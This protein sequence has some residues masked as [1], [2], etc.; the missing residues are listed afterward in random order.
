MS[1]EQQTHTL[2]KESLLEK[3][4]A[5]MWHHM[6]PYN[7]NPMIVTEASGSWVTD[8]DGNKYLDGMSG[9]WC[10]NIGYGRQ[11]LAEAAYEQ[12]KTMA[13]F[14]LTQSHVPAIK[15]SEKVSEWLGEEYRVFFSNSGSEANEVAFKIARQYH[16]QN[17]E[18]GR[19]K[20]ISRHRAYHGNTMGALAATG[21][22]IRKQ[23]YEPL[24]PGFLHVSPPYCYRCPFGKSYGSCSLECAQVFDEV[25]NWEGA[26]SV[27]AV[28]MEPTITG[29]GVIVP[30]P[31][32]MPKVREICD[33]YGVLLIVDEVICGFGRSGQKFGHQN[34]GIKPDIVTMAKGITSAYLPLSATAVRADIADKFNEQGVNLHFRHVN[35]FG[36]NP[37]ACALALKNLELMEEE[38]MIERAGRLG[39]ELREKLSFLEEH[40]HV[41]DIRSFGFLMGIEMVENRETKEPAAPDKLTKV[42]GACKQRGL[43]IGR[44]GDTIPGFNNVLTLSPPFSTTSEDIDF[45]ARVLR[46]AFAELA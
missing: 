5:H 32:Y 42:I 20:F 31:E 2:E 3:D 9:L 14:P 37:A 38:Q 16:H 39:E 18:P 35:T 7:P 26:N 23:K 13:Y 19:Y 15:L 4:R 25:I 36:G 41:G 10:V 8:I 21:Q 45:I 33:K 12:L 17:G 30:P 29:G 44:N 46:E 34:F 24:A 28:I 40:L 6:S 22:S 27:A 1:Q 11:E 43:I